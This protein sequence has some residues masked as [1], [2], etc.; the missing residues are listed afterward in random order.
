MFNYGYAIS[1]AKVQ[2]NFEF[3]KIMAIYLL[4]LPIPRFAVFPFL[5][6]NL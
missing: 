6:V 3:Q 1:G 2:N 5:H 4:K